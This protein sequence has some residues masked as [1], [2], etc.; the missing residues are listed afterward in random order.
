VAVAGSVAYVAANTAGLRVID[1]SVPV[2]PSEI[3]FV[4]TLR[5]AYGV[6]T[7][8]GYVIVV[9]PGGMEIFRECG[10][11]TDGFESGDTSAWSA[12]VP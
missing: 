12:T 5:E 1:V 3:G 9:G 8:E 7:A 2:S 6:A 4:Q 10:V 11:F